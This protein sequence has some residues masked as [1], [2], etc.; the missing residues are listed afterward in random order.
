MNSV[1]IRLILAHMHSCDI[2]SLSFNCPTCN[3]FVCS[4]C[5]NLLQNI[6]IHHCNNNN[7]L[8][9]WKD[10]NNIEHYGLP[11]LSNDEEDDESS[12]NG[13]D[14]EID[15]LIENMNINN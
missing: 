10:T 5:S 13:N 9:Y 2:N 6:G 1:N 4:H 7:Y 14:S 3:K 8:V 12:D 15:D 11:N